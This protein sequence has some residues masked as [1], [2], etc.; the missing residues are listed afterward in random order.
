MAL[1]LPPG[2]GRDVQTYCVPT[3]TGIVLMLRTSD[4]VMR[5]LPTWGAT[6]SAFG[7]P[8]L[9]ALGEITTHPHD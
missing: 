4:G 1:R 2:G 9:A 7:A 6:A 5:C 3:G 8:A